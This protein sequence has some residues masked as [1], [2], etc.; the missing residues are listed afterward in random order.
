MAIQKGI[1]LLGLGPGR[2]DL[3]TVR[4]WDWLGKI[5]EIYVRTRQHPTVAA[6]PQNLEIHSFD[7]LYASGEDFGDVYET[8]I[9]KIL[10]LGSRPQGVTYAVP[11]HP[12]VAEATS[13]EILKRARARNIPV[14]LID[15]MSFLEPVFQL[16]ELDP[17]PQLTLVDALELGAS[18]HP[19]FP[20][21]S[22][23]LVAQIYSTQV[24][25]EVKLALMAVYPDKHPVR[26]VHGAGNPDAVVEDLML[27]EI[28][29]SP[30]T[31]LLTALYIP[32]LD[33][34][35]SFENFLDVIAQ[36]RA[37][38]GCPWDMEQTHL[39]LRTNL[40]EETY[41]LLT[42][43]D[44]ED[45]AAM[46]EEFGDL[47]LQ[48]VL[49]AQ[50][51]SEAG[52]FSMTDIL[53]GINTKIVRR[54]P[55]VFG[56]VKLKDMDHLLVNWEKL[57]AAERKENGVDHEKGLLDGVPPALPAL[58]QAQAVQARAAR[59][60]FDWQE[61]G[62]VAE[63]VLEEFHEVQTA[64]NETERFGEVGDL[65]FAV[66]NL[67]RWLNVDAESALRDTNARFRLRFKHIEKRARE[68][69][70]SLPDM[71]LAEMDV[72][73]EEAKKGEA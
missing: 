5:S 51:A 23:A 68:A 43:L 34:N 64:E 12:L 53:R 37:P 9:E 22:P 50:I 47:L 67:A 57:K 39:S 3:L 1:T 21:S 14:V 6:F 11:G 46:C 41:E 71:T 44:E 17:F 28:D 13:P 7:D 65:L 30:H 63:K 36:L 16:L 32:P 69:G 48:I 25:S 35:A 4:A 18:H 20:P 72:F 38:D 8:I 45:T 27:Y 2:F 42:A 54:H 31:G 60:G 15:G 24:A 62:P 58:A 56:D 33:P 55:H 61:I 70:R 66:V 40:L 73:W 26:M 49:H 59:V 19:Q 52:E 29:R 10:E